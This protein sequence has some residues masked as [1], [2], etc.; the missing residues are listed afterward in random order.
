M[1]KKRKK[2]RELY[3]ERD[4]ERCEIRQRELSKK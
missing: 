1:D 4:K 2:Q 3:R